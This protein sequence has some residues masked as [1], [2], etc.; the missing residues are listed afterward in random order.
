VLAGLL[1]SALIYTPF[2]CCFLPRSFFPYLHF[3]PLKPV[4]V[5]LSWDLDLSVFLLP[6][7][8]CQS[9][10]PGLLLP[11]S[12][13]VSVLRLSPGGSS[14][15]SP[16][17]ASARARDPCSH[18]QEHRPAQRAKARAGTP[19]RPAKSCASA[20]LVQERRSGPASVPRQERPCPVALLPF[21]SFCPSG[22]RFQSW[23]SVRTKDRTW[24]S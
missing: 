10:C 8:F 6:K 21:P 13:L 1:F 16:P 3:L 9:C 2:G 24:A 19:S 20:R 22:L 7:F 18:E 4:L 14:V 11:E 15:P 12:S 5:P 17:Q 23:F